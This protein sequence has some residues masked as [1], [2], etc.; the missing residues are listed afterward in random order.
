MYKLDKPLR[1]RMAVQTGSSF[2]TDQ[3]PSVTVDRYE[4]IALDKRQTNH[5][6]FEA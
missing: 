3:I 4:R 6:I 2:I 1:I 5:S